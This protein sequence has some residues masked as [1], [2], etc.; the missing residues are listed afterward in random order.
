MGSE[1]GV[2]AIV[3]DDPDDVALIKRA[4]RRAEVSNPL[5]F[6]SDGDSAVSYLEGSGPFAD[7]DG[8]QHPMLMLLDLK[9]PRRSG[10][11]VLEWV[12]GRADLNPLT[13]V[14]LTSSR[15]ARDLQRA[16]ELGVTSYLVKPV[17]FDELLNLT[18]ALKLYWITYNERP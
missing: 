6:L 2:I 5:V 14:V 17:H 3:E 10:L 12:R 18:R 1:E 4:F 11:E 15:E 16:Y 7:R 13:V 8:A 9:L